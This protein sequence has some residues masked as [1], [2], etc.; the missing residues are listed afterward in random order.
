M[1]RL[2]RLDFRANDDPEQPTVLT[3]DL[4]QKTI[5]IFTPDTKRMWVKSAG[6]AQIFAALPGLPLS[7]FM[8][9]P[10]DV[11]CGRLCL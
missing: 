9:I 1:D 5:V 2:N 6:F 7:L 3:D 8:R 4:V 11:V 10:R